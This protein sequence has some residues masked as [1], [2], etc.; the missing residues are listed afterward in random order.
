ML[1]TRE[2]QRA[3][4][5]LSRKNRIFV[6]SLIFLKVSNWK[7]FVL[8]VSVLKKRAVLRSRFFCSQPQEE[9]DKDNRQYNRHRNIDDGLWNVTKEAEPA[10]S[11]EHC[12]A[13]I[14]FFSFLGF[15]KKNPKSRE[16]VAKVAK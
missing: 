9:E 5:W 8:K 16:K 14:L 12:S 11:R 3:T 10:G 2:K 1:F 6:A 7:V 13:E 15:R 4:V